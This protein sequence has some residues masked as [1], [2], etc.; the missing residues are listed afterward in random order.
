MRTLNLSIAT[1][2]NLYLVEG[3]MHTP[4]GYTI[5]LA[6]GIREK[7][8]LPV[9]CTGRINDPVMAERVLANGQADMIGMCRALIVDPYLPRSP[10]KENWTTCATAS[11]TTRVASASWHQQAPRLYSEPRRRSREDLGRRHL[12]PAKV[13]KKVMIIGAGPGGMWAA[14]M[15]GRR[16]HD[17]TLLDRN[18]ELGGQVLIAMKGAGRDKF[19]VIIP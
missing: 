17:V 5:P 4:L 9:F 7:V 13:K 18:Q 6:P 8:K 12:K 14:R 16:G 1:F 2:Y 3:S 11:P 10:R 15:A 19:G